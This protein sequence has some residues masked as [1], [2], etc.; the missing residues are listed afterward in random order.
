MGASLRVLT[1]KHSDYSEAIKANFEPP[2]NP[3]PHA[4]SWRLQYPV[5]LEIAGAL[6]NDRDQ[7]LEASV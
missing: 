6:R 3:A 1:P 2:G 7:A 5:T 4:H